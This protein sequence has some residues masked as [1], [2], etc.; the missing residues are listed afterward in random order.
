MKTHHVEAARSL[1]TRAMAAISFIPL[2]LSPSSC[3]WTTSRRPEVQRIPARLRYNRCGARDLMPSGGDPPSVR[4]SAVVTR[5]NFS[6]DGLA[7]WRRCRRSSPADWSTRRPWPTGLT[8]TSVL[9]GRRE[10][11][12]EH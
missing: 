9:T 1:S 10:I 2:A 7:Q 6:A 4:L 8:V 12:V 3:P 11:D 5:A